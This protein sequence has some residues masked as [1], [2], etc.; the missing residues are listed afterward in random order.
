MVRGKSEQGYFRWFYAGD[1]LF[2]QIL[3]EIFNKIE[4]IFMKL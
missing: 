2:M 3:K 1:T 4:K